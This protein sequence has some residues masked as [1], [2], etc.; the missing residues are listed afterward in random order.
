MLFHSSI[1]RMKRTFPDADDG[2]IDPKTASWRASQGATTARKSAKHATAAQAG[3]AGR[4]APRLRHA[5]QRSQ[6]KAIARAAPTSTPSLRA[7]VARPTS[8]P[9]R[10]KARALPRRPRAP[11]QSAAATSGW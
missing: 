8:R 10:A 11:I 5:A 2:E 3:M 7:R 9:P 4:R 1:E 6:A